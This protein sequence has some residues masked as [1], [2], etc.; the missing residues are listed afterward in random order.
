MP[1]SRNFFTDAE[2]NEIVKTIHASED[3]TSGEIKVHIE[4]SCGAD[5]MKRAVAVFHKI[6][7]QK[8]V[9]RNGVLI[10]L[11]IKEKQFAIL[12]D[13]GINN[14]VPEN[15]WEGIKEGMQ[16]EFSNGRFLQGL[17]QGIEQAGEQLKI[18]FPI[19]ST[20]SNELTDEISFN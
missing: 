9:L 8:T 17:I 4:E 12:A 18:H 1:S 6:N 20:D 5:V 3:V 19:E 14:K 15:F 10:Y 16:L 7:L 11:A 2:K 13:E